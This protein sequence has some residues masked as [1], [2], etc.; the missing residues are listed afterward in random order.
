MRWKG[1]MLKK[2]KSLLINWIVSPHVM[3]K[4]KKSQT[5]CLIYRT[6]KKLRCRKKKPKMFNIEP[7]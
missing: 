6:E 4:E 7:L 5:N 3:R 2:Y 1:K